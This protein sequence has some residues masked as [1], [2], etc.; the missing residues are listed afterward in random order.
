MLCL[1]GCAL[2][3]LC[4]DVIVSTLPLPPP[5]SLL[6]LCHTLAHV[7]AVS[8][9]TERFRDVSV[10]AARTARVPSAHMKEMCV[11]VGDGRACRQERQG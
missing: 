5:L 10:K 11:C 4:E 6:S 2:V 1:Y 9:M 7:C 3:C 8:R